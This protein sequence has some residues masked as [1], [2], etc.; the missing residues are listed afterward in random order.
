M[1]LFVADNHYGAYSGRNIYE[2]IAADYPEMLFVED[3]WSCFTAYNLAGECELLILNMI[4]DT[5][6]LAIPT[7]DAADSVRRYCE[8]GKPLLL[9]HGGS[10][11]FW[12]YKWF[13]ESVGLRWVRGND[14]DGVE[15][16]FHPHES[17]R[18]EVSKCR[19]PLSKKLVPMALPMDE[20]YTGL[21][22]TSPF[23]ILLETTIS[24]GSFP[25][26]TESFSRW[27]GRVINFLPG[28]DPVA[29]RCF[30]L[31][32]NVKILIDYLLYQP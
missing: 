9:L 5:C 16:S 7:S 10:A 28:H 29:T 21:E 11:A 24:S 25:Q 20:I 22:Q 23:T 4:A 17:Y 14:P 31:V 6:G 26:C 13:R 15:A 18:V 3:D 27:G 12:P 8:E 1:I 19:H 32:K 2:M 30:D